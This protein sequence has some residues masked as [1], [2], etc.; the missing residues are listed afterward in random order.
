[1]TEETVQAQPVTKI[2]CSHYL[3]LNCDGKISDW[4]SVVEQDPR[5]MA[6]QVAAA[7]IVIHMF[8][9][10][11]KDYVAKTGLKFTKLEEIGMSL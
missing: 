10:T 9:F 2:V 4:E 1:M 3:D 5:L 11:F 6:L 7:H 8:M